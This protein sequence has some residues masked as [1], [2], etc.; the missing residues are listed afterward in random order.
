MNGTVV[1]ADYGQIAIRAKYLAEAKRIP[2]WAAMAL[3]ENKI[4]FNRLS[5]GENI[6]KEDSPVFFNTA[7]VPQ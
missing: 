6:E 5:G 1:Y 7:D 2:F 4:G 3:L